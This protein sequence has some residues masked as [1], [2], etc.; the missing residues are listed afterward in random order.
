MRLGQNLLQ[1]GAA[2]GGGPLVGEVFST[3]LYTGN[4]STQTITN[5]IDLAGEGGMVWL[6]SRSLSEAS[7]IFDTERGLYKRLFTTST[8]YQ[9]TSTNTLTAFNSDGFSIGN[10]NISNT[11]GSL[12]VSWTFRKAP[13]FFDVVT[14]TGTGS[15][16]TVAHNLGTDPGLMIIKRLDSSGDWMVYHRTLGASKKITLHERLPAN[17]DNNYLSGTSP[18]SDNFTVGG[19]GFTNGSGNTYVAYLF[20]HD[21]SSGGA[22]QCGSYTGNGSATGPTIS[23]GWEPQW[24]LLKR[25]DGI[26]DWIIHD[27]ARDTSNPRTAFLEP[28][29]S[30][31]EAN[32]NDVDFTP[33]GFQLKSTSATVNASGGTYTYVAIRA[34]GA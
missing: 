20:A 17:T 19:S 33:S 1:Q 27:S 26:G 32:G 9:T 10:N 4:G 5:G 13:Q 14:Y 2:G 8:I 23:L 34:G 3:S 21:P 6:K 22:I 24:L 29:T 25:T 15:T 11:S 7:M 31:A 30:D 18:T 28:N 12:N 16:R